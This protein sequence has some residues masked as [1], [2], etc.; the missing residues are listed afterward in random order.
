[1]RGEVERGRRE[2][3]EE[4]LSFLSV[5]SEEQFGILLGEEPQPA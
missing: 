4:L 1:M 5:V 3:L 2:V